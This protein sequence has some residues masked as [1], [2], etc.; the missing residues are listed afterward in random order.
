MDKIRLAYINSLA[1]AV[2]FLC[3][4][5]FVQGQADRVFVS[6]VGDDASACSRTAPCRTFAGT[7]SRVAKNGEIDVID[8]G[9]FGAVTIGKSVTIDGTGVF[10]GA[11]T[12]IGNVF[13]IAAGANDVV[14][15]RSLSINGLGKADNGIKF[16]SGKALH[17]EGCLIK[18]FRNYGV[19]FEPSIG[20]TLVIGKSIIINNGAGT[21]SVVGFVRGSGGGVLAKSASGTAF[22][23]IENT[24][25][26]DNFIGV[27]ARDNSKIT[28][29]NST[30]A[31]NMSIGLLAFTDSSAPA[32]M[33]VEHSVVTL[34][35]IG[36]QSGG[37][38]DVQAR[39]AATVRISGVNV[40]SNIS[41]GLLSGCAVPTGGGP[42]AII[43]A[44]NN[45]IMGNNPDGAPTSTSP[46][47]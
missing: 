20:G 42:A 9:G 15:L 37:C 25:M 7:L 23:A 8:S 14:V 46:Q 47:Q 35:L 43:S 41:S 39:G 38:S 12:Q 27:S 32:E 11:H 44:R 10:A 36:I 33:N 2:L 16:I 3:C 1:A 18:N 5:S 6:A 30:I 29:S 26:A 28:V 40:T 45:T 21:T 24:Q 19:D 17:L 34:N 13:N 22:V 4:S 31:R